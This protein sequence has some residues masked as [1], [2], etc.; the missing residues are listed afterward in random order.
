[1]ANRYKTDRIPE[2]DYLFM[3]LQRLLCM[4]LVSMLL[5]HLLC[6]ALIYGSGFPFRIRSYQCSIS[7]HHS[8][9]CDFPTDH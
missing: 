6:A 4:C 3:F 5:A 2:L 1:M 9:L 7:E 8:L